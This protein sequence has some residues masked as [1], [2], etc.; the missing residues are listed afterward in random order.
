M[1]SPQY[2]EIYRLKEVRGI[3]LLF[4]ALDIG[5]GFF[6][7]LSLVF[8]PQFDGVAA[9][10]YISVIVGHTHQTCRCDYS[11]LV[12]VLDGIIVALFFILNPRA[13]RRREAEAAAAPEVAE[14][15]QHQLT[16]NTQNNM[17]TLSVESIHHTLPHVV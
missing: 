17:P 2:I 13:R 4:M 7:L 12:K 8:K 16:L 6:S 15:R 5:G 9:L 14:E 3:S 1:K 11:R 10:S